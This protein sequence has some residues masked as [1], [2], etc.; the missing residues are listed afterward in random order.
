M[1]QFKRHRDVGTVD[2]LYG[3]R[4]FRTYIDLK[5]K[6]LVIVSTKTD[7]LF[8]NIPRDHLRRSKNYLAQIM[9]VL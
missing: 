7:S 9:L 2:V 3:T 8:Y 1:P 4:A 5:Q 6:G